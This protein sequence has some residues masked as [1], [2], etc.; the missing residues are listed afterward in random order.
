MF[1]LL[2]RVQLAYLGLFALVCGGVF[3]Y[4]ATYIWPMQHCEQGGGWWSAKY[5]ECATPMPI[6]RLTGRGAP[7]A[8]KSV[9]ATS[10]A[11]RGD[12]TQTAPATQAAAAKK[13]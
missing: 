3:A 6:W 1:R 13:P 5:H 8:A 11:G 12:A 7:D 4:E 10:A 2:G 9:A